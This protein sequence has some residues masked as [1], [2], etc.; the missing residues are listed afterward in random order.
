[1]ATATKERPDSGEQIRALVERTVQRSVKAVEFP[2]KRA[3]IVMKGGH[4]SLIA[5]ANAATRLWPTLDEWL[6]E[7]SV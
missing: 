3:N 6:A 1:M 5:G 2:M 4:I 7:R